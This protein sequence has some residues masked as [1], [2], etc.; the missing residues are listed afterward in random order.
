[1]FGAPG[2]PD[3]PLMPG[4]TTTL[5]AAL[6][7]IALNTAGGAP[8]WIELVPAG[9]VMRGHDGRSW[10]NPDPAGVIA[11]TLASNR[12]MPLDRE[13]AT[14]LKGGKGEEAPAAGWVEGLELRDGAIWGR[15]DW[16]PRGKA[17]V[18]E[19]E[20]RFVS[21]V[22]EYERAPPNRV[23][24]LRGGGLTNDPNLH[25][26]AL[27]RAV[28]LDPKQ[29]NDVAFTDQVREA[30]GLP[31][32]ADEA[33]ILAAAR[34]AT[35][36]CRAGPD[37]TAYAPRAELATALNRAATAETA[38]ATR[39][40]AD[41]ETA[42]EA[43]LDKAQAE[44]KLTPASRPQA[45]AMCK[46]EG[47]LERFEAFAKTLPRLTGEQTRAATKPP[48]AN[49]GPH[50][51]TDVELATCRALSLDPAEFAKAKKAA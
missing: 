40:A 44:G 31:A 29:E 42:I 22:F 7:P 25:L 33:A 43:V 20:Y 24:R 45:L 9:A 11:A 19:R 5:Q 26:T 48:A 10:A 1:M 49:A 36:T 28:D 47:G 18:G 2:F 6:P 17:Q 46:A 32:T 13:H 27:N 39:E 50:D 37:L 23:L 3:L 41:R 21:P 14:Q 38:L 4:A 12:P 15:V 30:L 16:T 34:T 8:E 35:A 51:L